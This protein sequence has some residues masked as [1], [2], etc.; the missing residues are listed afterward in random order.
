MVER[1]D[2]VDVVVDNQKSASRSTT[3]LATG[4][5]L[6][7]AGILLLVGKLFGIS[8]GSYLWPFYIII[9]GVLLFVFALTT[10]GSGEGLAITGSLV[11]MV[12]LVLL[13][14]NTTNH[15]QS[16]AYAWALVAPTSIGLGQVVYGSL[17]SR[18]NI[19]KSGLRLAKVG[20]I[21]FLIAAVF[22][23]LVIGIS[24]FGYFGWPLLLIGSGVLLLLRN[25]MS[26]RGAR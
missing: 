11:T 19:V 12:G 14:Q 25:L 21:I 10:E 6:V 8:L 22:F 13:Y 16:W 2:G 15:W 9:P 5:I 4:I 1:L 18:E 24:G 20:G 7:A 26:G 3:N 17:K 23:E